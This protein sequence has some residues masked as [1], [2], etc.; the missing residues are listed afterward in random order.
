[1][2]RTLAL[3]A[4]AAVSLTGFCA[5]DDAVVANRKWVRETLAKVGVRISTGTVATNANGT[6]T[7]S[8][9]FRSSELTNAASVSMTFTP[10]SFTNRVQA[11][12]ASWLDLFVRTAFADTSL[13]GKTVTMTLK[14]FSWTDYDGNVQQV[15]LGNGIVMDYRGTPSVFPD[16][17][18]D[19]HTCDLNS[20][21]ICKD[22]LK[23]DDDVL[24]EAKAAYPI[25]GF[26]ELEP[27]TYWIDANDPNIKSRPRNGNTTYFLQDLSGCFIPVADLQRSDAWYEAVKAVHEVLGLHQIECIGAYCDAHDCDNAAP[28]HA[29]VTHTCGSTTWKTCSRS[30]SH[31]EGSESHEYPGTVYQNLG[32]SHNVWCKC[33]GKYRNEPHNCVNGTKSYNYADGGNHITGWTRTDTCACTH[34]HTVAHNCVHN[35]CHSCEGGDD[36]NLP[37]QYCNGSHNYT[38]G[39]GCDTCSCPNCGCVRTR[40][41]GGGAPVQAESNHSGWH[42]CSDHKD[43]PEVNERSHGKHCLCSCGYNGCKTE[44][45][46]WNAFYSL[47]T[48]D[49]KAESLHKRSALA[50]PTYERIDGDDVQHWKQTMSNCERTGCGD[51]FGV[52]ENHDFG[53]EDTPHYKYLSNEKC[54]LRKKCV[55]IGC[56]HLKFQTAEEA[57]GHQHDEGASP[58]YTCAGANNEECRAWYTCKNCNTA[59]YESGSHEVSRTSENKCKCGK[60]KTYQFD[61]SYDQTDACGNTSCLCG[62]ID[63]SHTESHTG[64]TDSGNGSHACACGKSSAPHVWG[65]WTLTQAGAQVDIYTRSCTQ[66]GC[67]ANQQNDVPHG[68]NPT[69]CTRTVHLPKSDGCGCLCGYYSDGGSYLISGVENGVP[70]SE[71]GTGTPSEDKRFHHWSLDSNEKQKCTCDCGKKH[72]FVAWTQSQKSDLTNYTSTFCP[73]CAYCKLLDVN[74]R[75]VLPENHVPK[76]STGAHA[77]CGCKCGQ[78]SINTCEIKKFH[79]RFQGGCRCWGTNKDGNGRFH[80]RID[81][82]CE[83]ICG[84]HSNGYHL[85]ARCEANDAVIE[86]KVSAKIEDHDPSTVTCGCKCGLYNT[87]NTPKEKTDFHHHSSGYDCICTCGKQHVHYDNGSCTGVCHGECRECEIESTDKLLKHTPASNACGCECGAP[88]GSSKFLPVETFRDFHHVKDSVKT[89]QC[90]CGKNH[91]W[92]SMVD[93]CPDCCSICKGDKDG[94]NVGSQSIHNFKHGK[95]FCGCDCGDLL[96][97]HHYADDQ[98]KC[99]GINAINASHTNEE[100]N[101]IWREKTRNV[102]EGP[103]ECSECG[104][105]MTKANVTYE[106]RRCNGTKTVE[107]NTYHDHED[108]PPTYCSCAECKCSSCKGGSGI[109]LSCS[110]FCSGACSARNM[111]GDGNSDDVSGDPRDIR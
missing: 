23:S 55:K 68:G 13:S 30:A 17:P 19:Q 57:G 89:C 46:F 100:L 26:D 20:D 108:N 3:L 18:S 103:E 110:K 58:Q 5:G 42:A 31:K 25:P 93:P 44:N 87:S 75:T 4:A 64:Y 82:S 83:N 36:C 67:T 104:M 15:D 77:G 24:A 70:W 105:E 34:S 88:G 99:Y 12:Q 72:N 76:D 14:S 81:S 8:S 48:G 6:I 109:C 97:E 7:F 16:V 22:A 56:G 71:T 111:N 90:K 41:S 51:P 9:P 101:H 84:N 94:Q 102:T 38:S 63:P 74:D 60:C 62:E 40:T 49:R 11:V 80:Y 91:Q 54:A 45:G 65:N 32:T 61:H 43:D 73:V 78:T 52:K 107:E 96:V 1:M 2:I 106:C 79:P 53:D 21:C 69:E 66:T 85:R 95:E 86:S 27:W 92:K 98:C 50:N 33:G 10:A 37:C 35:Y 39:S 59:Y 29:W 28:Q 47:W